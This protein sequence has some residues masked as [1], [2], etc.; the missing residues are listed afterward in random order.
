MRFDPPAGLFDSLLGA[1]TPARIEVDLGL[2]ES[3]KAVPP[4]MQ[5]LWTGG[6]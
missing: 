3:A 4:G 1:R 5:Y 6:L 2:P